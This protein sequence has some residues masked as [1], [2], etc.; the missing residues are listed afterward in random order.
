MIFMGIKQKKIEKEN[1]KMACSKKLQ[2]H[3]FSIFL[4]LVLG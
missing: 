4:G 3:Q 2:N 1:Y